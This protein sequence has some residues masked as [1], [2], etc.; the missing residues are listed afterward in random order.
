MAIP[1]SQV[2]CASNCTAASNGPAGASLRLSQ[3][4]PQADLYHGPRQQPVLVGYGDHQG[5][6]HH[7]VLTP[8]NSWEKRPD[9]SS[10]TR[11]APFA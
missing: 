11:M 3:E 7:A 9:L 1:L 2:A 5:L 4:L 10:P 8:T 6:P